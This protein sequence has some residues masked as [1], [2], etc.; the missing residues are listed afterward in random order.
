[1]EKRDK[2]NAVMLEQRQ[3]AHDAERTKDKTLRQELHSKL[4]T[5]YAEMAEDRLV[6][7]DLKEKLKDAVERLASN[8]KDG[9]GGRAHTF[10]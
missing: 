7:K 9:R 4:R 5:N 8:F 3:I 2:H 6:K 1:V 10:P